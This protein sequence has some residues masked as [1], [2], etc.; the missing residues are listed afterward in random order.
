M[1]AILAEANKLELALVVP[2]ERQHS[3]LAYH[4]SWLILALEAC[5]V[6]ILHNH[7]YLLVLSVK[8]KRI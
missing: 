3:A 6:K 4:D 8:N 2:H 7:V 5:L 1:F